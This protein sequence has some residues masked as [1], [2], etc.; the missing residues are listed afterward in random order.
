VQGPVTKG[1]YPHPNGYVVFEN[2]GEQPLDMFTGR[3]TSNR[4]G[5]YDLAP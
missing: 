1:R 3:T 5:H 2:A 4:L